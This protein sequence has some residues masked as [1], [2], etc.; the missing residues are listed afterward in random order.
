[1]NAP[2][3]P[4]SIPLPTFSRLDRVLECPASQVLPQ[5][6]EDVGAPAHRGHAIHEFRE[7]AKLI[8]REAALLK[9]PP[10]HLPVCEAID[11]EKWPADLAPEVAFAINVATGKA[12]ELGRNIGREYA[13]HGA[14][15]ADICGSVDELGV[16]DA[17]VF[18]GDGKTG[19]G[20]VP[21]P[22]K[23]AQLLAGAVAASQVYERDAATLAIAR[24]KEDGRVWWDSA[25]VTDFELTLFMAR[26]RGLPA[27]ITAAKA[28]VDAGQAP[29]VKVGPHCRYCPAK[30]SCPAFG[31]LMKR[32]LTGEDFGAAIEKMLTAK[33]A[34]AAYALADQLDQALK[35]IWE[36]IYGFS[37]SSPI[38]TPEGK[39]LT[40]YEK[41]E[42]VLDGDV[43]FGVIEQL[44][45]RELADKAVE[46]HATFASIKSVARDVA[47]AETKAQGKRVTIGSVEAKIVDAVKATPKGLT[48]HTHRVVEARVPK[49]ADDTPAPF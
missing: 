47:V 32:M 44:H 45:G 22:A 35:M 43:V 36:A 37:V 46:R 29:D 21:A 30:V 16:N 14:T 34:T 8:G 7:N 1:M 9:V 12:R 31:G 28:K 26:L 15:A 11:F 18:I 17:E 2:I 33:D 13:K 42:R 38:T 10:E 3:N 5:V 40:E 41:S 48:V 20:F 23:N 4:P 27:R 39:V 24:I 25:R 6:T 19:R 49:V